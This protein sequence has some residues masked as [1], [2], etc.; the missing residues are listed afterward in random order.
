[1]PPIKLA[2]VASTIAFP[3]SPRCDMGSVQQVAA[4]A[5]VRSGDQNSG[6]R[7]AV[8]RAT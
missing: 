3:P 6:D 2:F 1:M 4:E 5:G 7:T 8:N